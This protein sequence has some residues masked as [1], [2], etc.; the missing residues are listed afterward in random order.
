MNIC[1]GCSGRCR[2]RTRPTSATSSGRTCRD[3]DARAALGEAATAGVVVLAP[4]WRSRRRS[5][6]SRRSRRS[7]P[8]RGLGG[9]SR[10]GVRLRAAHVVVPIGLLSGLLAVL[11]FFLQFISTRYEG[12]KTQSAVQSLVLSR[13]FA[14]D[15]ERV[16][17]RD[18]RLA[19][20]GD[21]RDRQAPEG[22]LLPLGREP[23]AR[24]GLL[25]GP[26]HRQGARDRA[27]RARAPA[28]ARAAVAVRLPP[29]R[30]RARLAEG[31][32]LRADPAL[33]LGVPVVHARDRRLL[34]LRADRAHR[35][36]ARCAAR[37]TRAPRQT[38]G[39]AAQ[40]A[41]PRR[42]RKNRSV[43][44]SLSSRSPRRVARA[45]PR[46]PARRASRR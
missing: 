7:R 15:G 14:P 6:R 30:D 28:A 44:C 42:F 39:R 11:P 17:A 10:R 25:H 3:G 45:P 43:A 2:C 16:P 27:V 4:F 38:D 32:V 22:P 23:A 13:Y 26:D 36:R 18:E 8:R 46:S 31:R 19:R 37:R 33:R 9:P 40:R 12:V 29:A 35:E 20:R 21:G 34:H 24:L 41:R 1:R 5:Q